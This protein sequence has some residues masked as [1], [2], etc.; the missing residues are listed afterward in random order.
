MTDL[1]H[2]NRH[3]D[4]LEHL[5]PKGNL[6][7]HLEHLG[8]CRGICSVSDACHP[9][10]S[11]CSCLGR[12]A[13]SLQRCQSGGA[14]MRRRA[15]TYFTTASTARACAISRSPSGRSWRVVSETTASVS[16]LR[17]TNSTSCPKS[18]WQSTTVPT[19]PR[20]RPRSATSSVSTTV[21]SSL[22]IEVPGCHTAC[23]RKNNAMTAL[24]D[25]PFATD[26]TNETRSSFATLTSWL[27]MYRNVKA[28]AA[29]TR[30]FPSRKG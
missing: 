3:G 20:F 2:G 14:P 18:P 7:E 6:P 16:P 5:G 9:R 27:F 1:T 30:L 19:S 26:K 29:P 12:A 23:S 11:R 17:L 13:A 24:S 22:N 10:C 4:H 15:T 25:F 8:F 21:S 28:A